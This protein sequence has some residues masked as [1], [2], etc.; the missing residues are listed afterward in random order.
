MPK[1]IKNADFL[2]ILKKVKIFSHIPSEIV[3]RL[4]QKMDVINYKAEEPVFR[5]GDQGDCIYIIVE[6]K[7]KL[8][9]QEMVIAEMSATDFFGEFSLLDNEPRSLSVTCTMPSK[10]ASLNRS[11]FYLV[12]KEHPESIKNIIE[13]LIKRIR[14]QNNKIFTYLKNRE[15][16][17][18]EEVSKKTADLRAN[19]AELSL[20]LE[21]LKQTQQQLVMKEMLASMGQL[22]AGIAHTLKNPLNFVNNFSQVSLDLIS[23]VTKTSDETEKNELLNDLKINIEKI[24][25]HGKRANGIVENML[26]HSTRRAGEKHQVNL[27]EL[28]EEIVSIAFHNYRSNNLRFACDI[29]KVF[30]PGMPEVFVSTKEIS[31]VLL[32]IL[33]NAFYAIEEKRK[34][35]LKNRNYV[36]SPIVI[37]TTYCEDDYVVISVKDNGQGIPGDIKERI[38]EPFFTTKPTELGNGLGLSMSNEI[39]KMYGGE[40]KLS[41]T[42]DEGAE[43][44]I[45]LPK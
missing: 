23:E 10:L 19:N 30:A 28:T 2:N 21:K 43:F 44:L 37:I 17:L 5:K 4:A 40:I 22:T 8:H 15:K 9:E 29:K 31:R 12:L 38:F 33:N 20:T 6:G 26:Q 35:E 13:A 39:V 34:E 11:D 16:E 45:F 36:Y 42:Y 1:H 18:E 14:E 32:N 7:V 25:A 27:N 41:N 3:E 24:N